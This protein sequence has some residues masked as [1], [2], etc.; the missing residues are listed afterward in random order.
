MQH[1]N[2]EIQKQWK[3]AHLIMTCE[4]HQND[5]MIYES[6]NGRAAV[7][8][9]IELIGTLQQNITDMNS[10]STNT[11]NKDGNAGD[12][13]TAE[14]M[15]L[16]GTQ[17]GRQEQWRTIT[18]LLDT[19]K[20]QLQKSEDDAAAATKEA[21]ASYQQFA[22]DCKSDMEAKH[23]TRAQKIRDRDHTVTKLNDANTRYTDELA[24]LNSALEL[25]ENLR[26]SCQ[27]EGVSPAE[28]AA[29]RQA[30]IK[31]LKEALEVLNQVTAH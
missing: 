13:D 1:D 4:V 6:K 30:E 24:S 21:K 26:Q 10:G 11:Q 18:V 5:Q 28:R 22:S 8:K 9:A 20:D 3:E 2:Y 16:K 12:E 19:M 17:E 23:A 15:E 14:Q 25:W 29:K 7:E 31:A 27:S